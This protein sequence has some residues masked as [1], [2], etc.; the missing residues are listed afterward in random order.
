[1]LTERQLCILEKIINLYTSHGQPVGSKRLV[2]EPEIQSSSATVRNEMSLLE[3]LGLI[4]KT[5]LSSG[6][7][8]SLKGYRFYIDHILHPNELKK[9][10]FQSRSLE[11]EIGQNFEVMDEL[12]QQSAVVLSKLT[13]FTAIVLGPETSQSRLTGLRLVPLNDGQVMVILITDQG[14]V[15][16]MIFSIPRSVS[17]TDLEKMVKLFNDQLVGF[18]LFEVVY[19]LQNEMPLL[20]KQYATTTDQILGQFEQVFLQTQNN[21][22]HISG[23][24]NL[25]D[26]TSNMDIQKV[27]SLLDLMENQMSLTSLLSGSKES[28]SVRIG[29]ELDNELFA[30]LSLVTARYSLS[31]HGEGILAVVGPTSMP[32]DKTIHL[33]NTFRHELPE[34]LLKYYLTE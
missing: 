11:R 13:N 27:K 32:Y 8:P 15:E 31:D 21:R 30:N 33:L 2:E 22:F 4:E 1:M 12:I 7:V 19:K 3:E 20:I 24:S 6:R 14:S 10:Q 23:K 34:L 29:E 16:N 18:T 25:L 28:I 26:L 5:H 9:D 17:S